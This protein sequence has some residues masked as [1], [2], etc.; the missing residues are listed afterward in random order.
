MEKEQITNIHLRDEDIP[1]GSSENGISIGRIGDLAERDF[2]RYEKFAPTVIKFLRENVRRIL[3]QALLQKY[4]YTE[5]EST[6]HAALEKNGIFQV[7]TTASAVWRAIN[8]DGTGDVYLSDHVAHL[9]QGAQSQLGL[10]RGIIADVGAG[11]RPVSRLLR[12]PAHIIELDGFAFETGRRNTTHMQVELQRL[13][14]DEA[15]MRVLHQSI[16]QC[17]KSRGS[18]IASD[19][20]PALDAAIFSQILGYIEPFGGILDKMCAEVKT[21]GDIAIYE[22]PV[23]P[24]ISALRAPSVPERRVDLYLQTVVD[25]LVNHGFQGAMFLSSCK[26]QAIKHPLRGNFPGGDIRRVVILVRK[27][28]KK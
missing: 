9:L 3:M 16:V 7:P 21:G 13:I 26:L 22:S 12:G 17:A 11:T 27:N 4:G 6:I 24:G 28:A 14:S 23:M 15:A 1:L 10:L 5:G 20:A 18:D 2:D 19:E 8:R 25:I